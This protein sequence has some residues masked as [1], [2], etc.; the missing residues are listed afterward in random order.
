[1]LDGDVRQLRLELNDSMH[2][3]A[4]VIYLLYSNEV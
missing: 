1:M 3:G 4:D 2:L